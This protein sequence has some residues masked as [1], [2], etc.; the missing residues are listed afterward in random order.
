MK[1]NLS[2]VDPLVKATGETIKGAAIVGGALAAK[3]IH[4]KNKTQ[5]E[6]VSNW[7]EELGYS[8]KD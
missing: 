2:K 6:S 3:A 1:R 8:G 7:R 4:D 5:K